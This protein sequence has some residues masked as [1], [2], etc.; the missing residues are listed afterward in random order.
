MHWRRH[1]GN[2]RPTAAGTARSCAPRHGVRPESTP[3]RAEGG[4]ERALSAR[5]PRQGKR[6]AWQALG[7]RRGCGYTGRGPCPGTAQP[8][9]VQAGVSDQGLHT[10][11][12]SARPAGTDNLPC[13]RE[14][15][16]RHAPGPEGAPVRP[17]KRGRRGPA[18]A[19]AAGGWT[20]RHIDLRLRT[21]A[22]PPPCG[23]S[24]TL[25][26][27]WIV[28]Q[29]AGSDT[30]KCMTGGGCRR[31]QGAGVGIRQGCGGSLQERPAVACLALQGGARGY[32][33]LCGLAEAAARTLPRKRQGSN[34]GRE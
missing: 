19:S 27:G 16:R 17:S 1:A 2:V 9:L 32:G 29:H 30:G 23:I 34:R 7:R 3:T 18:W 25:G 21:T 14:R 26:R 10:F 12:P 15:D 28:I 5:R 11:R 13:T 20:S 6:R 24:C 4:G 31:M 22:M 8:H 33:R